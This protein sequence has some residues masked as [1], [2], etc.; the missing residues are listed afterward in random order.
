L[1]TQPAGIGPKR[2]DHDLLD[3]VRAEYEVSG[4]FR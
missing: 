3:A 4:R 2:D 1:L